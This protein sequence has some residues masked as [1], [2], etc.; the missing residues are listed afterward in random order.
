MR[1][2]K[3]KIAKA[4]G[5]AAAASVV[6][7]PAMATDPVEPVSIVGQNQNDNVPATLDRES[8]ASQTSVASAASAT[9]AR[10]QN[11]DVPAP[12][13]LGDYERDLPLPRCQVPSNDPM[14][15]DMARVIEHM[16]HPHTTPRI[17]SPNMTEGQIRQ[18]QR[19]LQTLGFNI[20]DDGMQGP[21]TTRA[22][23]EFQMFWGPISDTM[24]INGVIDDNVMRHMEYYAAAAQRDARTYDV[25]NTGVV[26]AIRMASLRKN[27]SFE[28]WM[29]MALR[30]S[31]F[32]PGAEART[33]SADGLFQHINRTID[34]NYIYAGCYYGLQ[35][36][37]HNFSIVRNGIDPAEIVYNGSER[38]L[39]FLRDLRFNPRFSAIFAIENNQYEV[40][41]LENWLGIPLQQN[42]QRYS[43]HFKGVDA[44]YFFWRGYRDTPNAIAARTFPR[45]ARA[46]RN[47]YYNRGRARTYQQINVW[48]QDH[49]GTGRYREQY[50][51]AAYIPQYNN[52]NIGYAGQANRSQTTTPVN[53]TPVTM[54]NSGIQTDL[55]TTDTQT[56]TTARPASP[57]APGV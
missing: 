39:E 23:M 51:V 42:Y 21:A 53:T 4:F 29:E 44:G 41:L 15:A 32:D 28:L 6:T 16:R 9:Q 47:I 20:D 7:T 57:P 31:S 45:Q 13:N 56:G 52:T 27:D 30:E 43:V 26:A 34:K 10:Q 22:V 54:P 12:R 3:R 2:T 14:Y 25:S 19:Y 11:D 48:F 17:I 8:I 38:D 24:Q 50:R 35:N 55:P 5:F 46:N 18:A 40:G 36:Y 33:S 37:V 49:F 1:P